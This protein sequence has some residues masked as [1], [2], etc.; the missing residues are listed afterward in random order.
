M[1]AL[2]A[3][4]KMCCWVA[5]DLK[6]CRGKKLEV[7]VFWSFWGSK[8]EGG[9]GWIMYLNGRW[10]WAGGTKGVCFLCLHWQGGFYRLLPCSM[11]VGGWVAVM[12][13]GLW[14]GGVMQG[15]CWR[16]ST[17]ETVVLEPLF[18]QL[19]RDGEAV[20]ATATA[21]GPLKLRPTSDGQQML[22]K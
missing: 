3:S 12:L 9:G 22:E 21:P 13:G 18:E 2:S 1:C 6:K 14:G 15:L 7:G 16:R 20:L 19:K 4:H 17:I 8:R 10:E 11:C 5:T